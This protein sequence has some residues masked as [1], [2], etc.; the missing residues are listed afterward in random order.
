M[1]ARQMIDNGLYA[2]GSHFVKEGND[3][4][5]VAPAQK[6]LICASET[7]TRSS[8]RWFEVPDSTCMVAE[9][10]PNKQLELLLVRY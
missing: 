1:S 10:L 6:T 2:L 3:D 8:E 4:S 7:L 5:M 9:P